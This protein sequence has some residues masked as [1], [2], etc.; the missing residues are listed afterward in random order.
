MGIGGVSG[1][2]SGLLSLGVDDVIYMALFDLLFLDVHE[3]VSGKLDKGDD[4]GAK[5]H[6]A[7]MVQDEPAGCLANRA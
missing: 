3:D 5:G 4:E 7:N 6:T 1:N 2:L